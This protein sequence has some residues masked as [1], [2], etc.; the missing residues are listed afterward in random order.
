MLLQKEESVKTLFFNL[1][2]FLTQ[3]LVHPSLN[4]RVSSSVYIITY[5]CI[6]ASFEI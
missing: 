2:I 6:Y 3:E 4:A 5:I 1:D